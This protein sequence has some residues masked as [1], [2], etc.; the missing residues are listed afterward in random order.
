LVATVQSGRFRGITPVVRAGAAVASLGVLLSL[1]AGVSRTVFAMAASGDLPRALEAVHPR[2][3]VPHHA[4]IAVAA[5]VI[6]VIVAWDLRAAIGFSSVTVLTYYAITN[7]SALTL[8]PHER[9]WPR[10]LA[11]TG[12]AGCLIL[13]ISLPL[14]SLLAGTAVLGV[15]ATVYKMR[16]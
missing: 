16:K 2:H 9:R 13:A 5:L 1:L 3:R 7:A 8:S 15:G 6:A 11:V 10:W 12:L 4:E 14:T